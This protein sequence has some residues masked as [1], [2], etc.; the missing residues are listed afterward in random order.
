MSVYLNIVALGLAI[1]GIHYWLNNKTYIFEAEDIAR[2]AKRQAREGE[3]CMHVYI[4]QPNHDSFVHSSE[5]FPASA[6]E[7]FFSS[8]HFWNPL[9]NTGQF[10]QLSLNWSECTSAYCFNGYPKNRRR[11]SSLDD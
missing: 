6:I 5:R 3:I 7:F 10:C 11:T 8:A 1:F 9:Q 2:I 4:I